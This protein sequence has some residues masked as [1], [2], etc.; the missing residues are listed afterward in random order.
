MGCGA[1]VTVINASPAR[2]RGPVKPC[3]FSLICWP[4]ARPEGARVKSAGTGPTAGAEP[5]KSL[6]SRL[7]FGID[8]TAV[9]GLALV[10]I[11]DDLV[12]SVEFGETA[13]RPRIIL[14]GVRVQLFGKLPV[15]AFDLRGARSLGY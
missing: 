8:L 1:T 13:R 15:R 14:I 2:P 7:A 9:E 5:L 4:S 6:E 10:G 11:A 3:P 12:G